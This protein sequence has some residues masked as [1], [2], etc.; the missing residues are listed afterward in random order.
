MVKVRIPVLLFLFTVAAGVEAWRL[1]SLSALSGADVW[2]H[3]S[4]GLWI[5]QNHSLPHSGVFSQFGGTWI[6][7]S[8]AY[9]L[10]LA[11]GYKLLGLRAIPVL[12]MCFKAA[13]AMVTLV[14]A[15]GLRGKLWTAVVLSAAAQY[16]LGTVPPAPVYFSILFFA[17][18][19]FLLF[20][21]QRKQNVR[22]LW[23][24][25]VLMLVWANLDA[26]FVDGVAVLLIFLAAL[27]CELSP[28][29]LARS[30]LGFRKA[31][32]I[33]GLS[34]A[35]TLLT[36]YFY[37]PYGVF[38]ATTFNSAN[39]YLG[40]FH[41]LG[42][43]QPQ[44]Y[45]VMLT[46]MTAFLALGL[47]RSR[48]LFAIAVLVGCV[49]LS[50]YSKRDVWLVTLAALAAIGDTMVAQ[51]EEANLLHVARDLRIASAVALAMVLVLA[52][53]RIPRSPDV[54]LANVSRSYP[55]AA[56]DSIRE[57]HLAQPLFNAYEWG[58]FLTWY[59]P[60]YP[61]AIDS[62]NDLY[63]ADFIAE[64]SKVMN[65]EAPYTEFT[66]LS[67]AQTI[68]LPKGTIM[69]AALSSLP[70]FK[71]AYSDDAAIVLTRNQQP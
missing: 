45:V 6:A 69:A 10:L 34:I 51:R 5:L 62:R 31:A 26:Q 18:E 32:A 24:L 67:G 66:S 2:W 61:V 63:G 70:V 46:V 49:A 38:F 33:I 30:S 64:Y 65:A 29:G 22:V 52:W 47:R 55:V 14:L 60:Q 21:G 48:N 41:A 68:L 71:V 35:A 11:V 58:G 59:L 3:L 1:T 28:L 43:R 36:P 23:W 17:V 7:P 15:G 42:F 25:P 27:A 13:L 4:S 12:L 44:D 40:E 53:A 57:Q 9:D 8:W 56:C 54:L 19:L 37:R 16:V 39:E 20:E 50:F